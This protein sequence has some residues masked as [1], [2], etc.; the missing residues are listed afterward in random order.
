LQ[1][2]VR[3]TKKDVNQNISIIKDINKS[4]VS[5]SVIENM[6]K[7][8][9]DFFSGEIMQEEVEDGTGGEYKTEEKEEAIKK[10]Q[11]NQIRQNNEINFEY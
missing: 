4:S 11:N 9:I 6:Q 10:A 7:S 3:I 8:K 1:S 2:T 5:S